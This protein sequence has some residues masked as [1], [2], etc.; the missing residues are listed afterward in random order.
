VLAS[1]SPPPCRR[2]GLT[3][4]AKQSASHSRPAAWLGVP[5]WANA[6]AEP[7]NRTR[8][9]ARRRSSGVGTMNQIMFD[10]GDATKVEFAMAVSER[11]QNRLEDFG[12][13]ALSDTELLAMTLQGNGIRP[14][15]ALQLAA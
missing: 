2:R 3:F 10:W 4:R 11:P 12:V 15:Q 5:R 1:G 14:E 6:R 13:G 7:G 8:C 9:P